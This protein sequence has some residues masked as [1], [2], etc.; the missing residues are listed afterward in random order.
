MTLLASASA[1]SSEGDSFRTA[2]SVDRDLPLSAIVYPPFVSTWRSS[3][4]LQ[5]A[6]AIL[7]QITGYS[8]ELSAGASRQ[9]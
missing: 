8:P 7:E 4:L 2:I 1:S 5:L 6:I 9:T 3:S